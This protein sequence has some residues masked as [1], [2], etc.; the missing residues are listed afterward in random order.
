MVSNWNKDAICIS[1]TRM[2]IMIFF[3][4]IKDTKGLK[5]EYDVKSTNILSDRTKSEIE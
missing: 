2:K 4:E 1:V 3:D 5:E